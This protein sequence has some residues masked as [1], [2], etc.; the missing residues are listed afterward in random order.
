MDGISHIVAQAVENKQAGNSFAYR[1][2]VSE[3]VSLGLSDAKIGR[4]INQAEARMSQL[5][6][7]PGCGGMPRIQPAA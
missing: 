1:Q 6:L 7:E 5:A 3:L 2:F 4:L